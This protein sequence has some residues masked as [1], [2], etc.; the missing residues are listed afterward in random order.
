MGIEYIALQPLPFLNHEV[1]SAEAAACEFRVEN[2]AIGAN[3]S[4]CRR[5]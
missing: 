2:A 1:A 5:C 3:A 4:Q